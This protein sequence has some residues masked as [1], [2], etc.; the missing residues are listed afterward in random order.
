VT[1]S[2]Y[3]GFIFRTQAE[4][5]TSTEVESDKAYL[6]SLW[7]EVMVRAKTT[8]ASAL[9][10]AEIPMALRVLRD[11]VGYNIEKVRVDN[12]L[13]VEEMRAYAERY[14]PTLAERIEFYDSAKPIFD[15]YHID[16]EMQKAL[17]RNVPLKSGG[18]I[19]F[20]QTEALT[21]IDVNT[22]SYLGNSNVEQTVLRTN[23][24][25]VE[26]IARQVRL[27]N[28]GGIIII[29]F[30]DMENE[31][32]KQDL[33]NA[34]TQVL[35]K[36]SARTKISELSSLGL[37]QMTRKRTRESLEHILCVQCPTCQKR[38]SIKSTQTVCS[39]IFRELQRVA[40]LFTW[41]GFLIK[42]APQ[43]AAELK[44]DELERLATQ[45]NV[46]VKF[47]AESTYAQEQYDILPLT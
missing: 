39:E 44:D 29:D 8:K 3:G 21:T 43:V 36:D 42:V 22:G 17:Q 7:A 31:T 25:A 34:L 11:L 41:P 18:H 40:Q 5:I 13:A 38:G 33:L 26:I 19:V 2:E 4:G 35:A 20:D 6:Q 45:L 12:A 27:R 15:L 10:Y 14:M 1:P 37:L 23:L 46:P 47:Q 24:E 30:I 28:L 16:A 32:H 9:V